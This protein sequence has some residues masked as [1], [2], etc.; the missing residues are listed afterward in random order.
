MQGREDAGTVSGTLRE[1]AI[2]LVGPQ[3]A[4]RK[5][6]LRKS[7]AIHRFQGLPAALRTKKLLPP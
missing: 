6:P 7:R 2:A 3:Q 4:G 5:A 1:V